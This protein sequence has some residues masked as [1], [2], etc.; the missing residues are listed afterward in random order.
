M[1]ESVWV[2]TV[3]E[4]VRAAPRMVRELDRA[5]EGCV[6]LGMRRGS[7]ERELEE[8]AALLDKR[9][10][11]R[12]LAERGEEI[13]RLLPAVEGQA[14]Y[15]RLVE[16]VPVRSI[17]RAGKISPRTA[18]R[19]LERGLA[20]AGTLMRARGWTKGERF[21]GDAW[22]RDLYERIAERT[23]EQRTAP[24]TGSAACGGDGA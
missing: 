23:P 3:L 4:S 18:Y 2:R 10:R 12:E 1:R 5:V 22:V 21:L 6:A 19:R 13:L 8:L 14:L 24:P 11:A 16:R 17:A 9:E 15:W 20:R 7:A